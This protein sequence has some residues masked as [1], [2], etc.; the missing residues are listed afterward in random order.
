MVNNFVIGLGEVGRAIQ[1][2]LGAPGY[3]IHGPGTSL[4]DDSVDVLHVCYPYSEN[5]VDI[6]RE[7]CE[8]VQPL[9]LVIHSTVPVGTSALLGAVH[10]PVRGVHPNLGRGVVVFP[11]WFGGEGAGYVS[12][13]FSDAGCEVRIFDDSRVT[14][15][16]KLWDTTQY[17]LMIAIEKEIH[18]YCEDNGLDF[19]EIYT[20]ANQ[21]YNDAYRYLGMGH[22]A[23]PVL[24]HMDGPIGGHC[25]L[26]NLELLKHPIGDLVKKYG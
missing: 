18:Q 21:E 2:V 8:K 17:G 3:D 20:K 22:V 14:E 9:Y 16:M 23:R 15:A 12:H 25:V 11:K 13:Y 1:G 4:P 24:R 10:S 26:A 19:D 5:F 6:T 7:Y